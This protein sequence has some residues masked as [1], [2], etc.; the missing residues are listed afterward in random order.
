[1]LKNIF[2]Y[3]QQNDLKI[4]DY[5]VPG[6]WLNT[7]NIEVKSVDFNYFYLEKIGE[8]LIQRQ[9][10]NYLQSISSLNS[11]HH[12]IGG[13]WSYHAVIYN[14]FPRFIT[15]FDHNQSQD[16]DDY[17]I[18]NVVLKKTGTFLKMIA[19]LPHIKALGV[20]TLHLMPI[21]KI[22]RDGNRGSLGSPYAIKNPYE[23][24]ENLAESAI[25]FSVE[26]QFKALIEACHILNIRV[27]LE[28]VMR[29]TSLD[30]DWVKTNPEWFYWI[31]STQ[32]KSYASPEFSQE[33]LIKIKQ[34][35]SGTGTFI[36]PNTAYRAI[37]THS[38]NPNQVQI[39]NGKYI[40]KTMEGELVIPSAF[41]DWPPDDKQPPWDDVTYLK[42]YN[43]ASDPNK[44]NYIAYDT[45]R[46]YHPELAKPQNRNQNLW[47]ALIGIIPH[48]QTNFGIDGIML[49]MG[50]ALPQELMMEII[51]V[52]RN[53]DPD[54]A[55]WEENFEIKQ[56]SRNLGFNATLGFEWKFTE[57]D[58]CIRNMLITSKKILPLPFFGTPETHNTPRVVNSK[59]KKQY[60][61]LNSFLPSCIP[62]IHAGFELN[63]KHPVNTGLNFDQAQ[64]N[65]YQDFPLP[66]FN[67]A[68]L[69]WSTQE[70]I[71]DFMQKISL[72]RIK[73]QNWIATGDERTLTIHYPENAFGKVIAFERHDAF[74]PWK[75]ILCILNTNLDKDEKFFLNLQGTYNNAYQE[76]LSDKLFNFEDHWLSTE[77]EAGGI[78][79]FELHK[80]L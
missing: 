71:C 77:I 50:H 45:I 20:N 4:R 10:K 37:F 30:S 6:M 11:E 74:Q 1:M 79:I 31:D 2:E 63:E 64:I 62:F 33:D 76:Y 41:A 61:V 29:T 36:A 21:T 48:Y 39:N 17:T 34:I 38:P 59:I 78:M 72:L 58:F 22:G 46:Y 35:P 3:L 27:V 44:F 5:H 18:N 75:S 16:L 65:E 47:D 23:L 19:L 60:W 25:P 57:H 8:I 55:F 9:N 51:E 68:Q 56:G 24:D 80:L 28:F 70:N 73:N 54:F 40:A 14:A 26:E 52:A 12:G 7:E 67:K 15:A 66:L 69:N 13:D 42:L 53:I 43:D 32:I 49:D